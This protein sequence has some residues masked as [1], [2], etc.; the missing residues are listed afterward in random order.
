M[1]HEGTPCIKL[2]EDNQGAIQMAE[3]PIT[4][5]ASKHIRVRYHFIREIVAEKEIEIEHV[6]TEDQHADFLTEAL[7]RAIFEYH[8]NFVMNIN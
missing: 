7:P 8:R 1:P 6:G 4:N 5:S 3:N 2:F